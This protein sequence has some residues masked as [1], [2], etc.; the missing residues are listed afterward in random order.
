MKAKLTI[1][2]FVLALTGQAAVADVI[3]ECHR[4]TLTR[5]EARVRA[6]TEIIESP[7]FGLDEKAGAYA[8][9]GSARTDAGA[10]QAALA[11]FTESV[12][13]KKDNMAAFVGRAQAK[14]I[15]GNLTGSI[16][17]YSEAIRL[18][19]GSAELYIE[20][21][22]VYLVSGNTDAAIRDC[23]QAIQL[24]PRNAIAR[25]E[26]GVA[27]FKQ[28]DLNRAHQDLTDAIAM[29]PLAEIYA[30]RGL[31]EEAQ[32]RKSDA[33]NDFRQALLDDPSLVEARDGLQ[34]L[35]AV[36]AVATETEQRVRQGKTLAE[37]NC[38]SCHAVG[39]DGD[40]PNKDAPEFRNLN[41]RHPLYWLRVP[42]AQAIRAT[43]EKM[44]KF[45][46]SIEELD[47]VVAYIYN[48]S[49]VG[50]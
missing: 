16:A 42:T 9:R 47:T 23:T 49:P 31:V 3:D 50:R 22:H 41:R 6:C 18:S 24:D 36:E 44:P 39:F 30:N 25:N 4:T 26:R 45:D 46:L 7:S 40:S 15:A 43:H 34:R 1:G 48:L 8:S 32:G 2:C 21:G 19:P 5:P 28:G 10:I 13:I 12:R 17:D 38:S 33:I 14:L 11:D 29:I 20:R 27:Y 35:G 37:K